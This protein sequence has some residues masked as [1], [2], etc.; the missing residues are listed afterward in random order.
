MAAYQYVFVMKGL[1]K[2]Y[3]GGRQVLRDIWLS[4]LPGAKIGVIGLNGAGKSTLLRVMA[5]IEKDFVGEAWA[6][7]GA[8][9]GFLAQ[10]PELDPQ[11][12]VLGNVMEVSRRRRRCST[13][14]TRSP[15]TIPMKPRRRCRPFKTRSMRRICGISS[16]RL[17]WRWT[18]CAVPMAAPT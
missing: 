13:A 18:R 14:T 15:P 11:L 5:G 1:G 6:S 10:E 7:E 9:I 16:H 17:K 4:F 2:T 3:T 8:R 12:N